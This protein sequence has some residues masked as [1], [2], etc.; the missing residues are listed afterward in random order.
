MKY[1][2]VTRAAEQKNEPLFGNSETTP[3][4]LSQKDET[5]LSEVR[6]LIKLLLKFQL[7]LFVIGF[8][9]ACSV[10]SSEDGA[11]FYGAEWGEQLSD[12]F[13]GL[14]LTQHAHEQLSVCGHKTNATH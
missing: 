7:K 14:L 9:F 4:H 6:L 1:S 12:I 5:E 3:L 8:T 10:W 13:L 2:S 11:L